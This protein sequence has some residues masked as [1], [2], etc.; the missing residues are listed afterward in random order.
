MQDID[1]NAGLMQKL[2]R[3]EGDERSLLGR[4]GDHCIAGG[5][6]GGNLTGEDRQWKI[7]W[8]DADEHAASAAATARCVSPVGPGSTIRF[9]KL[10]ARPLGIIAQ[11]IDRLAQV[12]HAHSPLSCPLRESA[13]P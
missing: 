1:R 8:A 6:R 3:F 4:L 11:E 2:H 9:D 12:R 7:P 10:L 13:A 5:Q